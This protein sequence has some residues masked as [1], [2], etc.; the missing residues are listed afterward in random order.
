MDEYTLR[1][2]QI[3]FYSLP[4]YTKIVDQQYIGGGQYIPLSKKLIQ[5]RN[6][7]LE[8]SD[9]FARWQLPAI[10]PLQAELDGIMPA[11]D[12]CLNADIADIFAPQLPAQWAASLLKAAHRHC[13][14]NGEEILI[15]LAQ[16]DNLEAW[17]K[18]LVGFSL[19]DFEQDMPAVM[20]EKI[21]E[22]KDT[23]EGHQL[24]KAPRYRV[25]LDGK[26]LRTF[27]GVKQISKQGHLLHNELRSVARDYAGAVPINERRQIL[28]NLL[29][30]VET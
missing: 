24:S 20:S 26:T 30:G 27:G 7:E 9:F 2:L 16:Q 25:Q 15:S 4:K 8:A 28:L 13:F 3:W 12:K 14:D 11:L 29:E 19:E 23:I 21:R 17:A 6:P 18:A 10:Q 5:L 1:E 22:Y